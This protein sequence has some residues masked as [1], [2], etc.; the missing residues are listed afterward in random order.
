MIPSD[1]NILVNVKEMDLSFNPLTTDSITNVLN[2]P[3]TVRSLNIA[4]TGITEVPVLETPFLLH[5]NLS[6]NNIKIINDDILAKAK[7]METL[8][9][10][11]NRLPNLS[12]GLA[13][14]WP[15]L[16]SM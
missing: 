12:A 10:S 11:Y 15:K 5:L 1:A 9:I 6:H 14:T 7:L 8:D 2:E 13:S 16:T 4:G 3:K